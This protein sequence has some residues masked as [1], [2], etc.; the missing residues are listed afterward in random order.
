MQLEPK[1]SGH[2]GVGD[3]VTARL[4]KHVVLSES[5]LRNLINQVPPVLSK[6]IVGRIIKD[7]MSNTKITQYLYK[8]Q[9]N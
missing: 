4:L 8:I 3:K 1:L 5:L 6:E 9:G 2:S 7:I